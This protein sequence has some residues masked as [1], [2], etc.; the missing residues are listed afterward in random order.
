MG[1]DLL[2]GPHWTGVE[3]GQYAIPICRGCE[4]NVDV[5]GT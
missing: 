3:V 2:S 5:D 1:L 4:P